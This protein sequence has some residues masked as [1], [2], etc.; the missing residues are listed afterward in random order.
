MNDSPLVAAAT[1]GSRRTDCVYFDGAVRPAAEAAFPPTDHGVL[2]GLG[3]FE[4]FRTSGGRPHQ[5]ARHWRRLLG[6]CAETGIALPAHFLA[7]DAT[8]FAGAVAELLRAHG[9]DDAVLRYTL[10]A[11]EP[12]RVDGAEIYD[13]PRELLTLRP[14]P[15]PAPLEG[16]TLRVL[17]L[18]RETLAGRPRPKSLN[19]ANAH[20]GGREL[21]RRAATPWDEGLFLNDAG[22]VIETTRQAI[23]W[24]RGEALCFPAPVLGPIAST[25][26]AWV[27]EQV[28]SLRPERAS[29]A[30]L[31]EADAVF[32]VNGV[33][34]VTAVRELVDDTDRRV[35]ARYR[36]A[37]HPRIVELQRRWSEALRSTA[38]GAEEA[39]VPTR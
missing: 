24:V 21:A 25:G 1:T 2:F 33:R 17:A 32:V 22:D 37:G 12:R 28:G 16:V 6:A 13:R 3:F 18:R 11:G 20:L 31:A 5:I 8:R 23:A 26:L 19:H 38:A 29:V 14:L 34:G 39:T 30:A 9:G 4:T 35:L 27:C 7:R 15:P 10:T 36:S